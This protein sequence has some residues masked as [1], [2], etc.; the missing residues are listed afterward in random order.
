MTISIHELTGADLDL[1]GTLGLQHEIAITKRGVMVRNHSLHDYPES[2]RW[3]PFR[4]SVSWSDAG[5]LLHQ[6]GISVNDYPSPKWRA[7]F[8]IPKPH[9]DVKKRSPSHH[10]FDG[11]TPLEAVCPTLASY[12]HGETF[13]PDFKRSRQ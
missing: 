5:P 1:A 3:Y 10:C 11:T 8:L 13:D 2:S 4:P 6:F 9:K 12:F 7:S